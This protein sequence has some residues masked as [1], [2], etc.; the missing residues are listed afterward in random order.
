MGQPTQRTTNYTARSNIEP[1]QIFLHANGQSVPGSGGARD[2]GRG[3]GG[4]TPSTASERKVRVSYYSKSNHFVSS[5]CVCARVR[6]DVLTICEFIYLDYL[7]IHAINRANQAEHAIRIPVAAPQE[8][9]NM[10]LTP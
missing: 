3:A 10:G 8:Y 1:A 9:I 6:C 5:L 7:C 4:H 2:V